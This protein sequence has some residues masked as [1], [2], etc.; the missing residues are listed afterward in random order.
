V[1]PEGPGST[2]DPQRRWITAVLIRARPDPKKMTDPKKK[3][4]R[5]D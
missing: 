2:E 3:G 1:L 4:G 5:R